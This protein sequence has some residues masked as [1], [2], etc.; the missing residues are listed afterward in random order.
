MYACMRGYGCGAGFVCCGEVLTWWLGLCFFGV[1]CETGPGVLC[2]ELVPQVCTVYVFQYPHTQCAWA[3]VVGLARHLWRAGEGVDWVWGGC[4]TPN[5][6]REARGTTSRCVGVGCVCLPAFSPCFLKLIC[7]VS[8]H[9]C[10]GS[11]LMEWVWC[12]GVLTWWWRS[13]PLRFVCK[14]G[15][16]GLCAVLVP[17]V[18]TVYVF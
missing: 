5:S 17:Q 4:L 14:T 2:A 3:W 8:A 15:L 12:G 7:I 1:V 10:T 11:N 16:G 18:C 9:M 6:V 13:F